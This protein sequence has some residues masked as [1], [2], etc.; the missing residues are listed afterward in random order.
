MNKKG[1]VSELSPV[2]LSLILIGIILGVGLLVM[3]QLQSGSY[4]WASTTLTNQAYTPSNAGTHLTGWGDRDVYCTVIQ[5]YNHSTTGVKI[6]PGNYTFSP[7]CNLINTTSEFS[8]LAE[9]WKLNYTYTYTVDTTAS[10]AVGYAETAAGT[11]AQIWIPLIVLVLAAGIILGI[12]FGAFGGGK[13][14]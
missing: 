1:N 2:I 11:L 4:Q 7:P 10:N 14:K 13:K 5:A 12:L 8:G 6:G 9:G 3:T